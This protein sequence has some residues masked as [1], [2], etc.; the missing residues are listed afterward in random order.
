MPMIVSSMLPILSGSFS[1]VA[2]ISGFRSSAVIAGSFLFVLERRSVCA[3][4][5]ALPVR[6]AAPPP[7]VLGTDKSPPPRNFGVRL[8]VLALRLCVI[9]PVRF[10]LERSSV[11]T[12]LEVPDSR[13]DA[14][15]TWNGIVGTKIQ[16]CVIPGG[17]I[18]DSRSR[19]FATLTSPRA[20]D[21][22][23]SPLTP[24]SPPNAHYLGDFWFLI[25]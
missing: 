1:I 5:P 17:K 23:L 2:N 19:P 8:G 15:Y 22:A 24:P 18:C 3:P 20:Q 6:S 4:P 21:L 10:T 9:L 12:T 11:L 13:F 25:S 14:T 16:G 7:G